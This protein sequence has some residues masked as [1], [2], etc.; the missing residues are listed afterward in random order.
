MRFSLSIMALAALAFRVAPAFGQA[1]STQ[2]QL[3]GNGA[4]CCGGTTCVDPPTYPAGAG[5]CF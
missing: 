3:C 5:I 1:C 4:S 2:G